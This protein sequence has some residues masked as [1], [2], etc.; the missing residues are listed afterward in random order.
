MG[1]GP[2]DP[3]QAQRTCYYLGTSRQGLV[4]C[5][6]LLGGLRMRRVSQTGSVCHSGVTPCRNTGSS[7]GILDQS[8]IK[9]Q[10]LTI[11]MV[12]SDH[13]DLFPFSFCPFTV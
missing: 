3:Q 9:G 7:S 8:P 2:T 11:K 4:L 5:C 1:P 6:L 12:V 13:I 10:Q